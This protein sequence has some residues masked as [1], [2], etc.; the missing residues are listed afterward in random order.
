MT[1]SELIQFFAERPSI[2]LKSFATECDMSQ[3]LLW[4]IINN[5]RTLQTYHAE[6]IKRIA[7]KYGYQKTNNES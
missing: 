4:M 1:Q 5:K 3:A 7:I 2:N 6:K